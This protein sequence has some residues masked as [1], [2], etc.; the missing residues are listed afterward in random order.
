MSINQMLK[1]KNLALNVMDLN[2]RFSYHVG[3]I[4]ESEKI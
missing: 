1:Q 2:P 4:N 3:Y